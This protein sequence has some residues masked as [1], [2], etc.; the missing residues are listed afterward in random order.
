MFLLL[1]V[2]ESCSV[3]QLSSG[4]LLLAFQ[5]DF[6]VSEV[7]LNT[8]KGEAGTRSLLH[9]FLA[10]VFFFNRRDVL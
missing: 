1:T 8:E 4:R 3:E 5:R 9:R 2:I 10:F 6:C 7:L